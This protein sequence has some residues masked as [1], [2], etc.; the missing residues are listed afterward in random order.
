MK[1]LSMFLIM[2]LC[3]MVLIA[4]Q[5]DNEDQTDPGNEDDDTDIVENDDTESDEDD[6][7]KTDYDQIE[8]SVEDAFDQYKDEHPDAKV[9]E[10]EL[11]LEDDT[12]EYKLEGY[13]GNTQYEMTIDAFSGEV[14]ADE[15]ESEN[16]EEGEIEK[17]DLDK[18]DEYVNEALEDAGDDYW[19]KEWELKI[20]SDYVKF[21][22]ELKND[23][24]D[25]NKYKYDYE[26]GELLDD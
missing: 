23:D 24:G 17:A 20:K 13:D 11:E 3:A 1:K 19:V 16:D 25:K 22:V 14:L 8:V 2:T 21:D 6:A 7:D 9:N 10:I 5:S 26:S 4:C 15:K 18:I 12:Y